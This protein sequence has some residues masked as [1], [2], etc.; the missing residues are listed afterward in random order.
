MC[1]DQSLVG[2]DR[3]LVELRR[4]SGVLHLPK[5]SSYCLRIRDI[6]PWLILDHR[7]Q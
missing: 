7:S 5:E 1:W 6:D 4:P 2:V 3:R